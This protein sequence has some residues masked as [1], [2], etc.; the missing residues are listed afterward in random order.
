MSCPIYDELSILDP[1]VAPKV[2]A[3]ATE[4]TRKRSLEEL[5]FDLVDLSALLSSGAS[6]S[7]NQFS[8]SLKQALKE[9]G[10]GLP[11]PADIDSFLSFSIIDSCICWHQF[12]GNLKGLGTMG[13]IDEIAAQFPDTEFLY[14][15]GDGYWECIK[16]NYREQ[17]KYYTLDVGVDNPEAFAKLSAVLK[18][19]QHPPFFLFPLGGMPVSKVDSAIEGVLSRVTGLVPGEK[20]YCVL[21]VNKTTEGDYYFSKGITVDTHIELQEITREEDKAIERTVKD[22]YQCYDNKP[23]EELFKC[24]FDETYFKQ[25]Y[26]QIAREEAEKEAEFARYRAEKE[27]QG[28]VDS[29]EDLPF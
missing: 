12:S 2:I 26:A 4:L 23:D 24:L 21:V 19:E 27:A 10:L 14:G 5:G 18:E 11:E 22:I 15:D 6:I 29:S 25:V 20:L 3:F 9:M 7:W 28:N 17:F 8:D 16:G 13:I 1:K